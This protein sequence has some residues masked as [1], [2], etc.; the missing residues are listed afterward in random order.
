VRHQ[1]RQGRRLF[2]LAHPDFL[3]WTKQ[4]KLFLVKVLVFWKK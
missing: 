4:L 3:E 1:R 2:A